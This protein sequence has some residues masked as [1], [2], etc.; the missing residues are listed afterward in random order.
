MYTKLQ[1]AFPY[2]FRYK[3]NIAYSLHEVY[4]TSMQLEA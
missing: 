4:K 3:Q 1:D 2:S